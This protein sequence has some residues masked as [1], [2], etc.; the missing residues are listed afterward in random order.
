MNKIEYGTEFLD[1]LK[2][3]VH[4]L[5]DDNKE[6]REEI[7]RLKEIGDNQKLIITRRKKEMRILNNRISKAIEYIKY[8]TQD[9][10]IILSWESVIKILE[11]EEVE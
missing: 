10:G 4:D 7:E 2:D 11:G 8:W 6:L 9:G 1:Q 5:Y 3:S